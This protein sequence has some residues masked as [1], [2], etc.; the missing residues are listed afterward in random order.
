MMDLRQPPMSTS[1]QRTNP[2]IKLALVLVLLVVGGAAVWTLRQDRSIQIGREAVERSRE[3]AAKLLAAGALDEAAKLYSGYLEH[4]GVEDSAAAGIAFSLGKGYLQ[5]GRYELALR[6][7]Y[8]AESL[9]SEELGGEISSG[10]VS[11]LERMGRH[12]A[13]QS[14]LDQRV[15]LD[16]D[17]TER[18]E[19]DVVVARIGAVEFRNSELE[20]ALD[21]LP[22]ELTESFAGHKGRAAFLEKFVADELIWR[23][24]SKMEYDRDPEV[25][26]LHD[27][28]L[29][30]LAV[31]KFVEQ[32]ILSKI[33]VDE[34][35]LRNHFEANRERYT[36][37]KT[38]DTQDVTFD[39]VRSAVEAEYR[40][41]KL[42]EAYEQLIDSELAVQDVEL[43]PE[44]LDDGS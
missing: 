35:D 43:Y 6:W 13:A 33:E 28:A 18:P 16:Q 14:A 39:Q 22:P 11:A 7:F 20:R 40:L 19:T 25:R 5:T 15:Q 12:H 2:V 34:T 17:Q 38:G 10:I 30:Q 27:Q 26:R 24:A 21:E 3:V 4:S 1:Q 42:Q 37:S 23:K 32:E 36:K 8:E 44:R 9:G 41:L 29:K 31:S